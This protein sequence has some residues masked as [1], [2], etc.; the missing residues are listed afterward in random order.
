MIGCTVFNKSKPRSLLL[1]HG[2]F[3]NSGYW[4]PYLSSLKD[5]RLL[6]LDL[7]YGAIRAL[8]R[9]VAQVA[10]IVEAQAG[11]RVDAVI[12]HSLGCLVASHLPPQLLQASY[13]ICP[14][15]CATRLNPEDFAGAIGRKLKSAL[16]GAAIHALL[17][18]ADHA[19]ADH[20]LPVPGPLQATIYVPDTDPYFHYH[21]GPAAR[22]FHGDHFDIGEAIAQ[23][24][25]AL[26]MADASRK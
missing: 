16:P 17:A 3:A 26:R 24:A 21:A 7:D 10:A 2:L 8:P 5:Y 23:V 1:L 13:E 9:Y 14:V 12:S 22:R 18:E 4:L 25:A 6:L 19:I 20:A 11:G 15:Y